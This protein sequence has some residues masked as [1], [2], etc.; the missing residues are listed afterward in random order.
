M[1]EFWVRILVDPQDFPLGITSDIGGG[2]EVMWNPNPRWVIVTVE[3]VLEIDYQ[4]LILTKCAL[5]STCKS[6]QWSPGLS[7]Y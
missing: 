6:Q 7:P 5:I 3:G 4:P 2:G 1:L